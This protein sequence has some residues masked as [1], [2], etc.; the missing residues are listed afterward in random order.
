MIVAMLQSKPELRPTIGKLLNFEFLACSQVPMFLPSSCLTM[1][2]RL[3]VNETL[4][5]DSLGH[6]KP[7]LELNGIKDDTRLEH[8]FLKNNL[9]DAITASAQV[10]RHNEDYRADI[11]SLYQQIAELINAKV[12]KN[13][14]II[15]MV[16]NLI[17]FIY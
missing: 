1:A 14:Y 2:P 3:E 15:F 17:I 16:L 4:A 5:I 7:L 9:H 12:H 8:T 11:E 13:E 10:F 6:R